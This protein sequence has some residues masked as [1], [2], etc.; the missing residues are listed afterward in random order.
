MPLVWWY[1]VAPYNPESHMMVITCRDLITLIASI[2]VWYHCCITR[3]SWCLDSLQQVSH[4]VPAHMSTYDGVTTVLTQVSRIRAGSRRDN[5]TVRGHVIS[6]NF[7][8]EG[9]IS[10][11]H[12]FYFGCDFNTKEKVFKFE[13]NQWILNVWIFSTNKSIF[14]LLML[15]VRKILTFSQ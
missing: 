14:L 3:R 9:D 13:F 15:I 6:Y 10:I 4:G 12:Y 2:I 11:I 1:P 8:K 5:H 7:G